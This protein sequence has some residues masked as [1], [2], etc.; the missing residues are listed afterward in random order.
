[1]TRKGPLRGVEL[2]SGPSAIDGEPIVA[3]AT[4][5]T[6]N[7]KTGG[8]IQTW[9]LR[10]DVPPHVARRTG[11]SRSVCGD[12]PLDQ[13]GCYVKWSEAPLG[14][15]RGWVRGIY[16]TYV[17]AEHARHFAGRKLRIG[18]AG[19]PAAVPYRVWS[20][21]CRVSAGWVGYTHQWR[22]GRYWR[23]RR[24]CMASAETVS[25]ARKAIAAGWR[26]FRACL[27]ES[28]A[29]QPGERWC[30]ASPDGGSKVQC[31]RC[32]RCRGDAPGQVVAIVAHGSPAVVH[33][34]RRVVVELERT[35][36][37]A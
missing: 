13:G 27:P 1:M 12:C 18:S 4:F 34:F 17:P 19:D 21:V 10:Q 8:V 29:L 33:A 2:Y 9:I 37:G 15:W 30:P 26:T 3:V 32:G 20:S 11:S 28:A 7:G 14:V 23:F 31:D 6:R 25:G 16:P 35:E 36:G 24:L 22:D 5:I